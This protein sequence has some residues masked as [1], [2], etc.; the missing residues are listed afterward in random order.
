MEETKLKND[1]QESYC[2]IAVSRLL[3]D[4]GFK[5]PV[6]TC[7]DGSDCVSSYTKVFDY[8]NYNVGGGKNTSR[9]THDLA[10]KW[11]RVNF[12]W[13]FELIWDN[14]NGNTIWFYSL[15]QVGNGKINLDCKD[16]LFAD[17]PEKAAE[18]ALTYVL[19]NLDASV[20][21][22]F[23]KK[24]ESWTFYCIESWKPLF[25]LYP[26]LNALPIYA[27]GRYYKYE[28]AGESFEAFVDERGISKFLEYN[29]KFKEF[30]KELLK[31]IDAEYNIPGGKIWNGEIGDYFINR[32]EAVHT[33][34][35]DSKAGRCLVIERINDELILNVYNCSS[36]E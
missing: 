10:M 11:L 32:D 28:S 17:S 4:K 2:S 27:W 5:V 30:D 26:D 36:P 16:T 6:Q 29:V 9:P 12:D 23:D 35:F 34:R 18:I 15:S 14:M 3:R 21:T 22:F 19:N 8:V 1:L 24:S 7:Y 25:D 13:H 20:E 33:F 31:K